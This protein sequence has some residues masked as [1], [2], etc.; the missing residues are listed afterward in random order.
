[1]IRSST[2]PHISQANKLSKDTYNGM[3]SSV[4]RDDNVRERRL[5]VSVLS[6]SAFFLTFM[7]TKKKYIAMGLRN[8]IGMYF[9]SSF[10]LYK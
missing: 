8:S 2:R 1:M 4:V 7:L 6:T 5:A 10:F 3:L 9:F